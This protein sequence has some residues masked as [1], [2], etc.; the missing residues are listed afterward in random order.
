LIYL[1]I[2]LFSEEINKNSD[3][4]NKLSKIMNAGKLL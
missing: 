2:N 1:G 3:E 4:L